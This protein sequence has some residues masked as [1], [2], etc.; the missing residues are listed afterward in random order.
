MSPPFSSSIKKTFIVS[1]RVS[2][3]I[4]YLQV[5]FSLIVKLCF[6][7]LSVNHFHHYDFG[8]RRA[9]STDYFVPN[10][11]TRENE[12]VKELKLGVITSLSNLRTMD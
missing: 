7:V 10:A 2:S 5:A 12:T 11:A 4:S 3:Y 8:S 9:S 1:L 6:D